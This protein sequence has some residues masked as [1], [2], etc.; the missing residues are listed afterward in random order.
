V[1]CQSIN[2]GRRWV[3]FAPSPM[4][5]CSSPL[6]AWVWCPTT[7]PASRF[8]SDPTRKQGNRE[9][10][11]RRRRAVAGYRSS[12]S[13]MLEAC[14]KDL[15]MKKFLLGLTTSKGMNVLRDPIF[16]SSFGV[17]TARANHHCVSVYMPS[18]VILVIRSLGRLEEEFI[19]I[20][21]SVALLMLD[22]YSIDQLLLSYRHVL[23]EVLS[24]AVASSRVAL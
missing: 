10:V 21:H 22:L 13:C 14:E 9:L 7:I 17:E 5:S 20:E 11:L 2:R 6:P 12:I 4:P 1:L 19:C 18:R 16:G 24:F 15:S 3:A 23:A 8:L